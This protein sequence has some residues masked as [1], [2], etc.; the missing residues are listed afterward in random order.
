MV[1]YIIEKK[2]PESS[3]LLLLL[4]FCYQRNNEKSIEYIEQYVNLNIF[5]KTY[6]K[7]KGKSLNALRDIYHKY[8]KKRNLNK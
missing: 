2:G 8:V 1:D 3:L 4:K 5:Q 6:Y 7:I